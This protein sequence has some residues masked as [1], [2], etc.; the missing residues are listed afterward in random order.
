M[1]VLEIWSTMSDPLGDHCR[2]LGRG[3]P[4]LEF[5]QPWFPA[6]DRAAFSP[7]LYPAIYVGA[8]PAKQLLP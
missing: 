6:F 8:V 3:E 2:Y 4:D 7:E 1:L 5:Q